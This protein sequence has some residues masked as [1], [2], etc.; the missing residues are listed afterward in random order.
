VKS[1]CASYDELSE[2]IESKL[3]AVAVGASS[4]DG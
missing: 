2:R 1:F 4:S 3:S